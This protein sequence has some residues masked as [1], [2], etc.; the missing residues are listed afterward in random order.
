MALANSNPSTDKYIERI[1]VPRDSLKVK[2]KSWGTTFGFFV[3]DF[4]I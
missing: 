4:S 3:L 2:L 1:N